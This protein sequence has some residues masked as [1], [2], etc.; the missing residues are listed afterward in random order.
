MREALVTGVEAAAILGISFSR[1]KVAIYRGLGRDHTR[2]PN[3]HEARPVVGG[4]SA[5]SAKY[6]A[7]DIRRMHRE[8]NFRTS[9]N[10]MP[11]YEWLKTFPKAEYRPAALA[12]PAKLADRRPAPPTPITAARRPPAPR[13]ETASPR[14]KAARTKTGPTKAPAPPNKR[15]FRRVEIRTVPFSILDLFPV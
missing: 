4:W 3:G 15:D 1:F 12:T 6:R 2:K 7:A 9:R 13:V 5:R 8:Y 14:A 11:D 10:H